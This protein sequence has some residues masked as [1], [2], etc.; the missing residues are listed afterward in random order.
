MSRYHVKIEDAS[1][2]LTMAKDLRPLG[3]LIAFEHNGPADSSTRYAFLT[4]Q[5]EHIIHVVYQTALPYPAENPDGTVTHVVKL[6]H[7]QT[8]PKARNL[9]TTWQD[10][11]D[12]LYIKT[13]LSQRAK[14][15][16]NAIGKS[17]AQNT[18]TTLKWTSDNKNIK[19]LRISVVPRPTSVHPILKIS[20]T[21]HS[22]RQFSQMLDKAG[23][24]VSKGKISNT[25]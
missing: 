15:L 23:F 20:Y 14:S 18:T 16:G 6:T 8:N 3:R 25:P 2:F 17:L 24:K 19:N 4:K 5:G 9:V 10:I 12:A 1:T 11:L 7:K 22:I 13:R 21:D